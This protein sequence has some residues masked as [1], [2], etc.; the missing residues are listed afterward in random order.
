MCNIS[1][2]GE[3]TGTRPYHEPE[4]ERH[5]NGSIPQDYGS[6]VQRTAGTF[7]R[8]HIAVLEGEIMNQQEYMKE[9]VGKLNEAFQGLLSGKQ[10]SDEQF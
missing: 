8:F 5:R 7:K 6:G 2:S 3:K 9:L 1:I 10:R 4:T